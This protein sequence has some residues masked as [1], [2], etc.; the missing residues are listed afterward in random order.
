M[1]KLWSEILVERFELSQLGTNIGVA[2]AVA[3]ISLIFVHVKLSSFSR[4]FVR[5]SVGSILM[6]L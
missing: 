3:N 2:K 5:L 6:M 1:R 4:T